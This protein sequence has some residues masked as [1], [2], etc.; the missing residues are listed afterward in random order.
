MVYEIASIPLTDQSL[1]YLSQCNFPNISAIICNM[2]EN[3]IRMLMKTNFCLE[4]LSGQSGIENKF[5]YLLDR[6][7]S[8]GQGY[9]FIDFRNSL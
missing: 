4:F 6:F 7:P 3:M 8:I 5:E 1:M 2:N 9:E